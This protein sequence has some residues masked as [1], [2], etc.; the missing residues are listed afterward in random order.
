MQENAYDPND[1]FLDGVR[2]KYPESL[3]K[4]RGG[5]EVLVVSCLLKD[6]LLYDDCDLTRDKFLSR[7][8]RF[9]FDLVTKLRAKGI[10]TLDYGTV[11]TTLSQREI[12]YIENLQDGFNTL[13]DTMDMV[14]VNNFPVYY[15]DLQREFLIF[16]AYDLCLLRPTDVVEIGGKR[17]HVLTMLHSLTC[18][19]VQDYFEDAISSLSEI[20][21][22]SGV[23]EVSNIDFDQ[24]WLDRLEEGV[25]EGEPFKIAFNDVFGKPI[26]IYPHLS[27]QIKGL[28]PR[29]TSF[30][31]GFSSSG[32]STWWIGIIMS[33][34]AQG[35]RILLISNEEEVS[36]FKQ[37]CMVWL[38][39][40]VFRDSSIT[41]SDLTRK[42][43]KSQEQRELLLQARKFWNDNHYEENLKFI[44][45]SDSDI[46]TV[47]SLIKQYAR[48]GFDTVIYDTFK[49]QIS[50]MTSKR[51]DLSLVRDSRTLDE[52]A[53]SLNLIVL[54]SVQLAEYKKG[55]LWLDASYLSNAK[56]IK[57]QAENGFFI[58]NVYK[59]ELIP[60]NKTKYIEPYY[61][62]YDREMNDYIQKPI[63][64]LDEDAV[65][66]VLFIEKCRSGAN[67]DDTGQ[68][69]LLRFDG[70]Y[71][72]FTEF[73]WCRPKR[74]S[75]NQRD[76]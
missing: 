16:K 28:L 20:G 65:W 45:I 13:E 50:D 26:Q 17:Q 48:M 32:K 35:H 59:E 67:S 19:Q 76:K 4:Y 52:L 11:Y 24:E 1:A 40:N 61:I 33:L 43:P 21:K 14:D 25:E 46:K 44:Q 30:L 31:G 69:I 62:E 6:L 63:S 68:A 12:D 18:Q 34:L 41:K 70:D 73:S 23:I 51:T 9:Y 22:T 55:G 36:K 15:D 74:G 57:E 47:S 38:L 2:D 49:I 66:K 42:G 29:T 37:K 7:D 3:L 53:K 58:R 5:T 71:S 8:G 54:Y 27:N 10:E 75:I 60:E 64:H 39:F 56:Q 72:T